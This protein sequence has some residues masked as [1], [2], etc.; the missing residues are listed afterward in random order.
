[1]NAHLKS[2]AFFLGFLLLTKVIVAPV[3]TNL[4]IPY[5]KDL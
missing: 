3:A 4:H 2:Y 1:M 5:I